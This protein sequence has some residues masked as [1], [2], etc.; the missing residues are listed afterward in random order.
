MLLAD[1]M[2]LLWEVCSKAAH[3]TPAD[4]FKREDANFIMRNTTAILEYISKVLS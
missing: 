4:Y 2:K 3:P 1:E